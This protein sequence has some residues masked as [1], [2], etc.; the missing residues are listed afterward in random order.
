MKM[1]R[2]LGPVIGS[3]A[4]IACAQ[5]SAATTIEVAKS[6]YCGCCEQW[7]EHMRAA[8]F[9]VKVTN[10]EDVTPVANQLGVPDSLRSC[11]TA[12]AGKYAIEGHVPAADVK[13]LLK[14]QPDALGLAVAGMPQGAPGMEQGAPKEHYK[15]IL[16]TRNGSQVFASH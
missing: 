4:I 2:V 9:T 14:E 3:V 16:F 7:I 1:F 15:T 5:A 6:P 11:H 13:R 12:K 8:G 10:V